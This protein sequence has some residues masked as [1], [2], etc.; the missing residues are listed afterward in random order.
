MD[1]YDHIWTILNDNIIAIKDK[2][3]PQ[4]SIKK[5]ECVP[6]EDKEFIVC[7]KCGSV[8]DNLIN[9]NKEWNNNSNENGETSKNV[10][11]SG[12]A[13]DPLMPK[14]SVKTVISG[15]NNS[16]ISKTQK[17]L[18]S[19]FISY[20]EKVLI[21]HKNKL[22]QIISQYSIPQQV[23]N[24]TLYKIKE[25]F[26]TKNENGSSIIHRG[27]VYTGLIGVCLYYSC[28]E[29]YYNIPPSTIIEMFEINTKIF[30]KCCKIYCEKINPQIDNTSTTENSLI[31][32]FCGDLGISNQLEVLAIKLIKAS[33]ALYIVVGVAPQS[34]ISGVLQFMN[35]KM[36][37][38][39]ELSKLS[40]VTTT[41]E[42]TIKKIAKLYLENE[43]EIYNYVK[44]YM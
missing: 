38:E 20:E 21:Q 15:S 9:S 16:N 24:I 22:S 44:F 23:I 34:N 41:S 39:I 13:P 36:G 33:D 29:K 5:C 12:S 14:S 43:L 2:S 11:R 40:K 32:R 8:L 31:T 27:K 18:D 25:M 3:Q 10:E 4:I 37:L 1:N 6:Y 35:K 28:K 42:L 7:I 17:W 30:S 19:G 26:Q